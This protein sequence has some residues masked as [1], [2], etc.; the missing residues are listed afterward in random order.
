MN[1]TENKHKVLEFQPSYVLT[2]S[3]VTSDSVIEIWYTV[4]DRLVTCTLYGWKICQ[5]ELFPKVRPMNRLIDDLTLLQGK[6]TLNDLDSSYEST[7]WSMKIR[8]V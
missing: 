7:Q 3:K 4:W 2:R 8:P 1:N 6:I 5:K